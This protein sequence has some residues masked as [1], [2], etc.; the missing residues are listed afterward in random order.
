VRGT[1]A[2][3]TQSTHI[4]AYQRRKRKEKKKKRIASSES[5]AAIDRSPGK[6]V[7]WPSERIIEWKRGFGIYEP[8][9]QLRAWQTVGFSSLRF[10]V[11]RR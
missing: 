7:G 11:A 8:R 10:L 1:F 3:H 5:L 4:A 2:G 9:S 6:V